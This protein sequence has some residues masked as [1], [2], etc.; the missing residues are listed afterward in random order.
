MT[1]P[2]FKII[3]YLFPI[4]R[5]NV[6]IP[7]IQ[8]INMHINHISLDSTMIQVQPDW[9]TSAFKKPGHKSL[10]SPRMDFGQQKLTR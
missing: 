5:D 6:N 2:P 3:E 1:K 8:V 7:N 9:Y 4:Q 10:E